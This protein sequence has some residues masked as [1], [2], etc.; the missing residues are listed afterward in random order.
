L[1]RLILNITGA[2]M[3]LFA[4]VL[5]SILSIASNAAN[6]QSEKFQLVCT[7]SVRYYCSIK[8][9]CKVNKDANPSVYKVKVDGENS[10]TIQ[11][12]IGSNEASSWKAKSYRKD[13]SN[14]YQFIEDG[15]L[16]TFS[17]TNDRKKF[18]YM[19]DDGIDLYNSDLSLN[20]SPNSD[21]GGQIITGNCIP[22]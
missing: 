14:K 9:G 21:L 20:K 8:T 3:K 7:T 12:Y 22:I 5:F 19:F 18:T 15:I 2:E 6:A 4:T 13:G 11:K 16:T 17:I 1:V 10:I